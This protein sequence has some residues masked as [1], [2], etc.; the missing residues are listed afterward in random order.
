M[1]WD[2]RLGNDWSLVYRK[3]G[4]IFATQFIIQAITS[5][6]SERS[7]KSTLYAAL[8]CLPLAIA[9]GIIGVAARYLYPDIDP[10]YA[11]PV[12][13]QHMN[14]ILSAIVATS[15]VASILLV[16]R[17]LHLLQPR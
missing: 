9:I 11:F 2:H 15:L 1:G 12:F 3:H 6:K 5:S 17:R 7:E 13:L 8:L 16:S 10:I 4:A 14:P